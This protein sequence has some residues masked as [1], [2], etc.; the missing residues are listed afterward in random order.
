MER[1]AAGV[2]ASAVTVLELKLVMATMF[3]VADGAL[4]SDQFAGV[5]QSPLEGFDQAL[6]VCA[7]LGSVAARQAHTLSSATGWNR[8]VMVSFR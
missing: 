4:A 3:W 7:W 1:F 8:V 2:E 5:C 6:T